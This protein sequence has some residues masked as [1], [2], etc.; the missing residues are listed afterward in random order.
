MLLVD[1]SR[2]LIKQLLFDPLS[3]PVLPTNGSQMSNW[4]FGFTELKI[5]VTALFYQHTSTMS[6]QQFL[7]PQ[8]DA[9][10]AVVT[11]TE[12]LQTAP[13]LTA[14]KCTPLYIYAILWAAFGGA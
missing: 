8:D 13:R 11:L 12:L 7:A 4:L 6:Q 10:S 2:A 5:P 3:D 14:Q 9:A 1:Q